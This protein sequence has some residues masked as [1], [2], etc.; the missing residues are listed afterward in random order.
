MR[1][2]PSLNSRLVLNTTI[3]AVAGYRAKLNGF[4][5]NACLFLVY[6]FLISLSLGIYEVIFNLYILRLGYRE[7]FLGFMLSPDYSQYL[8]PCS[9]IG[10]AERIHCCCPACFSCFPFQSC[11]LPPLNSC[12]LF[13]ALSMVYPHRSR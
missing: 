2:Y 12:W 10:Q 3:S 4:S 9:A 6:V 5:R 1:K 7:D 13:S 11:T 8:Q